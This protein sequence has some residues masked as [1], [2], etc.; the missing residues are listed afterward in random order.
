MSSRASHLKHTAALGAMFVLGGST[1][2]LAPAAQAAA[3]STS[4]TN[5][6]DLNFNWSGLVVND[7]TTSAG[8][9]LDAFNLDTQNGQTVDDTQ[10]STKLGNIG[11]IWSEYGITITGLNK[12]GTKANSAPLGLFDSACAPKNGSSN[13]GFTVDCENKVNG[14][15][16]GDNDLATGNGSYWHKGSQ[17][18][19]DTLEQG[20]LL[21]FEE[22]K[23]NGRPDD[24]AGGGTFLFDIAED[25]QWTIDQI[26]IVDDAKGT[27]T[28][29]YR[30]GTESSEDINIKGEN[31]LKFFSAAQDKEISQ[32]AVQFKGSGGIGGLRF[33]EIQPP[34]PRVPE[35]ASAMGLVLV[36]GL[37]SRL[38]RHKSVE[39]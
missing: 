6:Y 18:T 35:P 38:R 20:N 10:F 33:R 21:I 3:I 15:N 26:A 11:D 9:A 22:N 2:L 13:N 31:E 27:I 1:L 23:G 17:I 5:I 32:V 16:H 37:A 19:Y 28:Y 39:A 14:K 12:R 34:I 7:D 36:G 24:I 30:D 4:Q 29:T 8:D 25:K